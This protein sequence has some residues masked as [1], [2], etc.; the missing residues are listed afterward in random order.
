MI[1]IP[2]AVHSVLSQLTSSTG[3]PHTSILTSS[4]QSGGSVIS[5]HSISPSEI[6]ELY[7]KP[8]LPGLEPTESDDEE[9][10]EGGDEEEMRVGVYAAL[11]VGTW[12]ERSSSQADT[13]EPLALETEVSFRSLSLKSFRSTPSHFYST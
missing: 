3:I 4:P 8:Y 13:T 2:S 6:Q 1:I 11:A 9:N 5:Y 10:G 12:N 7:P